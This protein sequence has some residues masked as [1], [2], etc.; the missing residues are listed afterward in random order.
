MMIATTLGFWV[1][2]LSPGRRAPISMISGRCYFVASGRIK[3][4]GRHAGRQL[5]AALLAARFL[6]QQ[7]EGDSLVK[8]FDLFGAHQLTESF[9]FQFVQ[10]LPRPGSQGVETA[11][12]LESAATTNWVPITRP[13]SVITR[14][15]RSDVIGNFQHPGYRS[16]Q[17]CLC[18]G[19]PLCKESLVDFHRC[20][21]RWTHPG[22]K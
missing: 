1:I 11:V 4:A 3:T 10:L 20:P 16:Q 14:T 17:T 12:S 2:C 18:Y 9:N 21:E 15:L 7:P 6:W 5:S 13:R 22:L 8:G 19:Q